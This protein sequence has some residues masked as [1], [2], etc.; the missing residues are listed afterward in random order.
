MTAVV[1]ESFLLRMKGKITRIPTF[2]TVRRYSIFEMMTKMLKLKE[3]M[4]EFMAL[5]EL[6][7]VPPDVW[8]ILD[9]FSDSIRVI[10]N[11]TKA[12]EGEDMSTTCYV[13]MGFQKIRMSFQQLA[14]CIPDSKVRSF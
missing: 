5:G 3:L 14:P 13:I 6:K 1:F 10:T 2:S 11:A 7:P 4:L 9:D 8:Q 12:L